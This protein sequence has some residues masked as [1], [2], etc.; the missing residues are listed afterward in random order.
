LIE[1]YDPE[2]KERLPGEDTLCRVTIIDDDEPGVLSFQERT[3][4]VRAKDQKADIK[5]LRQHGCDGI[6]KCKFET[7]NAGGQGEH[8]A[9][10]YEDYLPISGLLVFQHGE[11]EKDIE[12]EILERKELDSTERDQ[13]FTVKVFDPEGGVKISKKDLC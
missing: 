8:T 1:L 9:A 12:V 4:K 2:T 10:P 7:Q 13:V 5:V 11:T 3:V 6:I